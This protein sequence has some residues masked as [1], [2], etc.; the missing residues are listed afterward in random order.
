M[1]HR[2]FAPAVLFALALSSPASAQAPDRTITQEMRPPSAEAPVASWEPEPAREH[3]FSLTLQEIMRGTEIVGQSPT[4]VSW[5]DDSRWIYFRWLPAG[6]DFDADRELWRVPAEGGEPELIDDPLVADSLSLTFAGGD[7]S[8]DRRWRATAWRGDLYLVDRE[9]LTVRRLTDTRQSASSPRFSADGESLFFSQGDQLHVLL[10]EDGSV[11]Q[12][13]DI[14]EGAAPED[15]EPEGHRAFLAEQQEELFEHIRRRQS[16]EQEQEALEELRRAQGIATVH[17]GRDGRPVGLDMDRHGRTVGVQMSR[18]ADGSE[19]V[20]VPRWITEDGY[21]APDEVRTKVGDAVGASWIGIHAVGA[22]SIIW[23]D[24]AQAVRE[25]ASATAPLGAYLPEQVDALVAEEVTPRNITFRGWNDA[26]SYG[27]VS[28]VSDDNKHR[29][30]LSVAAESGELTVLEHLADSAWVAGPCSGCMG[31]LPDSD[32]VYYVSEADR[33]AHLYTIEADGTDRRQL[34]SGEWE[35]HQVRIPE[36]ETHFY[37]RT[38]E[39]SPFDQH[40]Y[41]MEFDGSDRTRITQGEGRFDADVSPDGSRLAIV[42]STITRPDEL[43]VADNA[44]GAEMSRVTTS[45]NADWLAFPWIE[46]EII[47]FEARDGIMVPARIYR[48]SDMGVESNGAAV[49]FVH[50]A[51]Y[52]QNVHRWWSSYY[53]EYMFHHFLAAQGFTVLDIDYRASAGYGR[54]WRTAIYRHMG[55]W[56]L[57]DHVD[58]V[59]WLVAN[60][61]V[62]RERI[63]IYGGS[64]G[65]FITLMALFTEPEVFHAGGAL[66]SVTDWAHYNQGYTSRILNLPQD[67]PE[68]YRQSSPIY[69]ADGLEGHLLMGHP[70]YDTN[71]HFSDIVRLTQRLIELGKENWEL[72]VYPTENHGMVEPWSW[73]DQYRRIYELF[74]RTLSEPRCRDGTGVCEV[75]AFTDG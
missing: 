63:G 67:D 66:R 38:N 59:D 6:H 30:I 7:L 69:F 28:A 48:P 20:V 8:P 35:V 34:T 31:W 19:Q 46:A 24:V 25:H 37:L 57:W 1:S 29:W 43:H 64:Y 3:A 10:L 16:R 11:R 52:L 33:F 18:Q 27:L 17:A 68:A 75:P 41:R 70:M 62:D 12:L 23:P 60:E 49:L 2:L 45:P 26:G 65:G 56:D 44:P 4:G 39:G 13:T 42:H 73:V 58:G 72:S 14:R 40:L 55:G 15:E 32:R 21:T 61:G 54:D 5:T 50:G 51:G 9:E 47:H 53:R 22:D 74:W 71:V 36:Q